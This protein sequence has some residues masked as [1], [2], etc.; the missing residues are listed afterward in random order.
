MFNFVWTKHVKFYM[1]QY[2]EHTNK[3]YI[4]YFFYVKHV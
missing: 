1:A 2:H 4:T 3:F